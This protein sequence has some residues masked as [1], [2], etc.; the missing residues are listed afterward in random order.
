MTFSST[1]LDKEKK[2][3]IAR[4][5]RVNKWPFNNFK[6]KLECYPSQ[7]KQKAI[8][9]FRIKLPQ[10]SRKSMGLKTNTILIIPKK[11]KTFSFLVNTTKDQITLLLIYM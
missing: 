9:E 6:L 5:I 10:I 1:C 2:L 4:W 11:K 7:D 8:C 3:M